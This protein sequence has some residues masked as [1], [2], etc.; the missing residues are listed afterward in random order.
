MKDAKQQTY[1]NSGI[2]TFVK[3]SN[4]WGRSKQF[5]IHTWDMMVAWYVVLRAHIISTTSIFVVST[6]ISRRLCLGRTSGYPR[7]T[8]QA[9]V[10]SSL[11]RTSL[12]LRHRGSLTTCCADR[13]LSGSISSTN[14]R[15]NDR[16]STFILYYTKKR[17]V[18]EYY[19]LQVGLLHKGNNDQIPL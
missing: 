17:L 10:S 15:G 9:I 8:S 3:D 5:V 19:A 14:Y 1:Y 11:V 4:W 2:G 6:G 18:D 16:N 13:V 12:L 7:T